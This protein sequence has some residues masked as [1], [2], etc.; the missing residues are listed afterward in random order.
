[1][2]HMDFRHPLPPLPPLPHPLSKM[3]E[4]KKTT[5]MVI[6]IGTTITTTT[7]TITTTKNNNTRKCA[8]IIS[9]VLVKWEETAR[10]L[11]I[12]TAT[13]ALVKEIETTIRCHLIIN[14]TRHVPIKSK[15]E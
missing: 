11:I 7:T 9:K 14:L 2:H 6:P 13:T 3:F 10:F 5:T 12:K 15:D 1:M 8:V 4:T